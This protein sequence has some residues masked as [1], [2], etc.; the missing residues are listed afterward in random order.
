MLKKVIITWKFKEAYWW[1]LWESY[2][3]PQFD[4]VEAWGTDENITTLLQG[5]LFTRM[6][7]ERLPELLKRYDV[8]VVASI[9]DFLV[10]NPEKYTNLADYL[11]RLDK[12]I[13]RNIGYNIMTAQGDEP[14]DLSKKITDQR[15]VWFRDVDYDRPCV[16]K[17]PVKYQNGWHHCDIKVEKD[18]DLYLLHLRDAN[19][20]VLHRLAP[21][22]YATKEHGFDLDYQQRLDAAVPI[23]EKWRVL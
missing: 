7:N 13:V 21:E 2:Y 8:A 18:P 3:A 17:I 5:R 20:D 12:P 15:H 9:D 23:P 4:R 14:L 1:P 22:R 6:I 16:T 11:D 10:P 19:L